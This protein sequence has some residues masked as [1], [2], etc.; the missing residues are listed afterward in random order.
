MSASAA[1]WFPDPSGKHEHR[2]WDG[3][4][5]TEHVAT[6]GVQAVDPPGPPPPPGAQPAANAP[7]APR[8]D[9]VLDRVDAFA[10]FGDASRADQ[11]KRQV[12][13]QGWG[14]AN[15]AAGAPAG[16][17]TIF[18]E[19]ILV[20]NQK[21]KLME[22]KQEYGVYDRDGRRIAS[23][24]QT[25]QS[26]ARKAIR[27]LSNLDQ[28]LPTRL[29]ITNAA[30]VVVL[31]LNRPGKVF[32]STIIVSGADG[33]EI[34]RIVQE[35]MIGKIRFGLQ[36]SDG[37][38]LGSIK[39]ENWRA[40]N[41]RIEDAQGQEIARITKT[42]EGLAKQMFT[43]ADNYVVQIHAPLTDPLRSLVVASALSVDTA[44]K[45]DDRGIA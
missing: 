24:N 2:Y 4:A 5:W 26:T 7:A 14:G 30:G 34:G 33:S 25:N 41:F 32:K 27:L 17:G 44:L 42:W 20:V 22:L 36:G 35:N 10:D 21:A 18:D 8:E 37:T 31:T 15:V 12:E 6:N 29:E 11:I 40:W 3:E 16:G 23:V 45:Q 1:G 39:A 38:E 9:G 13:G 28:F 43:T 19:P